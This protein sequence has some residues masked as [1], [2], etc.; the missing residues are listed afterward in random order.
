MIT[1]TKTINSLQA[2]KELDGEP[3]V[4]Y[5]IYWNMVGTD[6]EYTGTCPAMTYVPFT[7]GGTFVPFDQLTEEIVLDWVDT[8][9]PLV[10]IQQYQ[11]SVSNA[12]ESQKTLESPPLPWQPQP[13]PPVPPVV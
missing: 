3:N 5:N 4:V 1:Y 13:V 8:Y 2:Y 12:I 11:Q 7:A 6:G 9:T 10:L